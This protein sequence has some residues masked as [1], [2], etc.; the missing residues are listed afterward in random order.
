MSFM[1]NVVIKSIKLII[2]MVNIAMLSV[3]MV[4]VAK[5]NVAMLSVV[6]SANNHNSQ[7]LG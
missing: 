7:T 1:L 6:V 5:L 3:V 4:H 2:I